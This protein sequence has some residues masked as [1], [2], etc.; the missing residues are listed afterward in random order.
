MNVP[1][2][3]LGF[4]LNPYFYDINYMQS[5]APGEEPRRAPN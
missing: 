3:C 4:A 5:P 2:H 1:M